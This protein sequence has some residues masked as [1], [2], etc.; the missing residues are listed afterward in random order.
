MLRILGHLLVTLFKVFWRI[1]FTALFGALV[2][3]GAVLLV[4]YVFA[5][6]NLQWPPSAMTRVLMVGVG[7]LA[8]YA[9]AVTVLMVEAVR[10]L[11][12]AAHAVEQE[13]A[14]PIKAV[15]HELE[16]IKP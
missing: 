16:G 5:D 1:V 4:S 11:K 6:N 8:G 13:A 15:E 3:V 2:G 7:L 12:S 9:G 14:A 10:A